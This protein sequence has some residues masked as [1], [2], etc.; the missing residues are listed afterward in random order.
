MGS[1]SIG[2]HLVTGSPLAARKAEGFLSGAARSPVNIL[3]LWTKG[4][5]EFVVPPSNLAQMALRV[6]SHSF[7]KYLS[8]TS[9]VLGTRITEVKES[10]TMPA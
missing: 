8:R 1:H 5:T 10:D 6:G 3:S 4:G 9:Y 2:R 7:N